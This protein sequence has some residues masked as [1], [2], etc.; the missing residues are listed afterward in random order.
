MVSSSPLTGEET[1]LTDLL[2]TGAQELGGA[3][4]LFIKK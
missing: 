2:S 3:Q 1:W 4:H